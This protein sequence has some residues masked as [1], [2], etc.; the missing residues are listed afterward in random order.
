MKNGYFLT[1]ITVFMVFSCIMLKASY[2]PVNISKEQYP[3]LTK[4]VAKHRCP[5][6]I[7][8]NKAEHFLKKNEY[9]RII[10][11]ERM[12]K[13]IQTYKLD[14]L[15][16]ANK[17]LCEKDGH[18]HVLSENIVANNKEHTTL[19]LTQMKQLFT[20]ALETGFRDWGA[21]N[22]VL[23]S[24]GILTFIDTEDESFSFWSTEHEVKKTGFPND[25]KGNFVVS[26]S[27]YLPSMQA[28]AHTWYSNTMAQLLATQDGKTKTSILPDNSKYDASDIDI[29]KVKKEILRLN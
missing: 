19:S 6:N 24:D 29:A 20:L 5:Q 15:C 3:E 13:V 25:C 9:S 7:E 1:V 10:N 12:K 17:Y 21:D 4:W 16:V 28:D 8:Q 14:Q 27:E 11:A 18:F 22:V 26:L 2:I 23:N